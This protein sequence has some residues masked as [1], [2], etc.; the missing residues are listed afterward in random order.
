M[1][2]LVVLDFDVE[3]VDSPHGQCNEEVDQ[4][5]ETQCGEEV[6]IHQQ[7]VLIGQSWGGWETEREKKLPAA[8]Y[9]ITFLHIDFAKTLELG[10][11]GYSK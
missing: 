10:P 8:L 5:N 2:L 4:E 1:D 3:F 9:Y 6:S 11:E 7:T